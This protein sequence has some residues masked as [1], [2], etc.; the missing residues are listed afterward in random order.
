MCKQL[1]VYALLALDRAIDNVEP[2]ED[3][4]KD[5]PK[6]GMLDA[7]RNGDGE[8]ASE[9]PKPYAYE[10]LGVPTNGP[11]DVLNLCGL[12]PNLGVRR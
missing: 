12:K 10:V 9:A 4:V 2:A 7:P 1:L 8:D 6:N 3:A 5:H 11:W